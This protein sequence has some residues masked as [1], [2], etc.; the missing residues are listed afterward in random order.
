[1]A[2]NAD[3]T[4]VD[5]RRHG[6]TCRFPDDWSIAALIE[7]VIEFAANNDKLATLDPETDVPTEQWVRMSFSPANPWLASSVNYT[8]RFDISYG[9]TS[10]NAKTEHPHG[11]YAARIFKY[12]KSKA[13]SWKKKLKPFKLEVKAGFLDDKTS[14]KIGEPEEVGG[15]SVAPLERNKK[16]PTASGKAAQ[17]GHHTFTWAK[18]N[19]SMALIADIPDDPGDSFYRG[20]VCGVIQ[21]QLWEAST[22]VRHS[23]QYLKMLED[24]GGIDNLS[25]NF[26]YTDGG[27]DHNLTFLTVQLALICLHL[28]TGADA[29]VAARPSARNSWIS[30]IEK[31]MC[32]CNY[33][34]YGCVY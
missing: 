11:A 26:I 10:R 34:M 12:W 14:F 21:D 28:A 23:T 9:L 27:P 15:G 5:D 4:R 32:I 16:T 30:C 25:L 7:S 13:S 19:P 18:G 33:A 17:A 22:A 24:N 20:Q 1:M 2:H 31:V 8:C 29:T 3:V 6:S